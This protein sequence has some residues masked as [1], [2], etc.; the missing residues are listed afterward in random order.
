[1]TAFMVGL[2]P[3]TGILSRMV[4]LLNSLIGSLQ[5]SQ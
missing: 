2:G 4:Q 3:I 1:L 5:S